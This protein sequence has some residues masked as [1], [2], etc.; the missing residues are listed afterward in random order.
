MAQLGAGAGC[1]LLF[2]FPLEVTENR[3]L[4]LEAGSTSI[5]LDAEGLFLSGRAAIP[6]IVICQCAVARRAVAP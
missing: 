6:L 3:L 4:E 2:Q 1:V 5:R